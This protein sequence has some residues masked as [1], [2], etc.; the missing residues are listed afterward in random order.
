[1]LG[2]AYAASVGAGDAPLAV[3]AAG[4]VL[5]Y[6]KQNQ[7]R[8]VPGAFTVR[9]YSPEA[10]MPLDAATVRN[11]ELP[12]LVQ[13]IDRLDPGRGPTAE[14]V[15]RERRCATRNPSSSGWRGSTSWRSPAL[16][17][18]LQA[19]LR[20]V[21]DLERLVLAR[22]RAT[23]ALASWSPSGIRW[24]P[25]PPLLH[26]WATA[27]PSSTRQLAA[28]VTSAPDLAALLLRALVEDPPMHARD[29]AVIRAGYDADLD[30]IS[31][32]SRNAREWIGQAGIL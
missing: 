2:I 5:D 23:P 32:G 21:G 22:R 25:S 16:R 29:G 10:T 3:G 15:A 6:L 1:M 24:R 31:E 14:G 9:T 18:R 11:L 28:D 8:V 13:L 12:A 7:T 19:V 26:R 17:D 30:A 4:V 20:P 27:P